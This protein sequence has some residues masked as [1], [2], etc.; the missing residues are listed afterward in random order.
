M[1]ALQGAIL[2]F[3][4]MTVHLLIM[5]LLSDKVRGQGLSLLSLASMLPDTFVPALV[6]FM[7]SQVA[8]TEMLLLFAGLGIINTSASA[9][10]LRS[11]IVV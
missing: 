7:K 8:T 2:A 3:F 5:D 10:F 6:L 1:R 11:A 9:Y 4:S